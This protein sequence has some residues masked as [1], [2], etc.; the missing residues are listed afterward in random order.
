MKLLIA[1]R[2][3]QLATLTGK[4]AANGGKAARGEVLAAAKGIVNIAVHLGSKKLLRNCEI[5]E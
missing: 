3:M 2:K 1:G 5:C 4:D